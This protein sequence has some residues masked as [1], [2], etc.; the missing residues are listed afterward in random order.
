MAVSTKTLWQEIAERGVHA[1]V[2]ELSDQQAAELSEQYG[3]HNYRPLPVNIARG[4]GARVWDAAGREY[5]DCIGAF[6]A[7]AH[8][9][10]NPAIVRALRE[11]LDEVTVISRAFYSR[12]VGLF[13]KGLADYTGLDMSCPMNSGAEAIETAMKL[14]RKWGYRVKGIP[15]GKA[16]IIVCDGNFHGRTITIVGASSEA[17]YKSDFGPY[18]PGFKVIPLGDIDALKSAINENTCAFLC[19]PIQA[20][21]GINIPQDGWMKEVR[22]V[23]TEHNVLL[24]WDEIQTGFCRTGERFAWQYED[25]KPDLMAVGKP[26]GGGALPVSAA[27]GQKHVMEVFQPGDH[28]STFGGN[29]LAAAVGL[30]AMAEMETKDYAGRSKSLGARLKKGLESFDFPFIKEIR[31]RGLLVGLEVDESVD[32]QAMSR[33]Y[34]KHGILTKETRKRTFRYT[35]PIIVSEEQIDDILTRTEDVLKELK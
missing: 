32:T 8:G 29:P 15:E 6:S 24:I 25:A 27:V 20:E 10:L 3:T 17:G 12:E 28:G 31:G 22:D 4:E 19:E 26:L 23:C 2:A 16:E 14:A 1:V 13:M 30:A 5:I 7:V 18:T 21:G 9:H 35:P 11:Q 34:V 33:A